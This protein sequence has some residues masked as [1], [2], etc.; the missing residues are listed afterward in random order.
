MILEVFKIAVAEKLSLAYMQN[1]VC[2]E[3]FLE[4]GRGE[5]WIRLS[6]LYNSFWGNAK[7]I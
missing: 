4:C 5:L 1:R 2:L 7:I 6:D 3:K